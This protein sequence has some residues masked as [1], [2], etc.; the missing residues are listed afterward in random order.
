M[1]QE[2]PIM[3]K[4]FV[5]DYNG[6]H[7][8]GEILMDDRLTMTERVILAYIVQEADLCFIESGRRVVPK[9]SNICFH[10]QLSR[11]TVSRAIKTFE[12][13]KIMKIDFDR[14]WR[15]ITHLN[16]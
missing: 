14:R 2:M 10:L 13:H 8:D 11:P 12:K 16:V 4:E 9:N 5:E 15:N 7:I 3:D 6:L 1:I